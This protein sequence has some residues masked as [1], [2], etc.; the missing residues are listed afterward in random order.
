MIDLARY[1]KI[2]CLGIGGIGLSAVAEIL[3]DNGH[4][5][6]GTDINHSE[7]TDHLE[8]KGIKI[9]YKHEKK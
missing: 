6:S 1:E 7:V 5:V 8:S 2:H 3:D 9:Y 4:I